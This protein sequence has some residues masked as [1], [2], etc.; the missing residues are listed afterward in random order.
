M[1]SWE[2]GTHQNEAGIGDIQVP[3][4]VQYK[5]GY[6]LEE[7][8]ENDQ[9]TSSNFIG[10]NRHPEHGTDY[11]DE[12]AGSNKSEFFL[13]PAEQIKFCDPI[14]KIFFI[15]GNRSVLTLSHS[16][17]ANLRHLAM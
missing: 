3:S 16:C 5:V 11:T 9:V 6:Q 4:L 2:C 14:I 17:R 10:K 15:C 13:G 12:K 1:L 8:G 7:K